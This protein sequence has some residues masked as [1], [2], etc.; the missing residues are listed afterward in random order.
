MKAHK[1]FSLLTSGALAATIAL[2]FWIGV[3]GAARV[4]AASILDDF[5]TAVRKTLSIRMEGID[6]GSVTVDGEIVL[7]RSP[8]EPGNDTL[9]AEVHVLLKADN[10]SWDDLDA[11]I[12]ICQTPDDSWH[13]CRGYG[14]TLRLSDKAGARRAELAEY[15][16]KGEAWSDFVE[17]PLDSFGCMPLEQRFAVGSDAVAYRFQK[18][19]RDYVEQLLRFLMDIGGAETAGQLI[20]QLQSAGSI[21]VKLVDGGDYVLHASNFGR[22]GGLGLTD[23]QLPDDPTSL[24]EEVVW[25]ITYDLT[26]RRI[27]GWSTNNWPERLAELAVYVDHDLIGTD[28][29]I[30]SAEALIEHLEDFAHAVE[31]E[32]ESDTI[33]TIRATGYP[34]PLDTTALEWRNQRMRPLIDAMTLS[35]YYDA[36][37]ESV[38]WAEFNHVGSPEGRI[39][40]EIGRVELDPDRLNPDYWITEH[41]EVYEEPEGR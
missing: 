6:L 8:E 16:V 39:M 21:V 24:L 27:R 32:Q 22:I 7:D 10:D 2:A 17:R 23:P 30:E 19:Q 9:Y 38:T 20:E 5:K 33:L 31:V 18:H 14:G 3:D 25:E 15:L 26:D 40:L 37:T 11:A 1:R 12:V 41:T 13:Y 36:Q 4:S 29:P 28:L 34:L 35:I